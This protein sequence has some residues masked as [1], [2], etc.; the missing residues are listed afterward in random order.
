MQVSASR[1]HGKPR[2]AGAS[3]KRTVNCIRAVSDARTIRAGAC[4]ADAAGGLLAASPKR[5]CS[6][7]RSASRGRLANWPQQ[8]GGTQPSSS[9][10]PTSPSAAA[11]H[12]L[13]ASFTDSQR[14]L[15][16]SAPGGGGGGGL[17][18]VAED[19]ECLSQT[20]MEMA[21]AISG[22]HAA[23]GGDKF[24]AG[25][26]QFAAGGHSAS[27]ASIRGGMRISH[28]SSGLRGGM[29]LHG[30]SA[31]TSMPL[32]AGSPGGAGRFG[33]MSPPPMFGNGFAAAGGSM[34]SLGSTDGWPK[35]GAP[36]AGGRSSNEWSPTL[37]GPQLNNLQ[38]FGSL[39]SASDMSAATGFTTLSRRFGSLH[40][41]SSDSLCDMAYSRGPAGGSHFG[42]GSFPSENGPPSSIHHQGQYGGPSPGGADTEARVRAGQMFGGTSFAS[43]APVATV[44]EP[45]MMCMPSGNG[46][47]GAPAGGP[48]S[49][50]C[51]LLDELDLGA[52]RFAL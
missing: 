42:G 11:R 33:T 30:F 43:M 49:H 37:G 40:V 45:G 8:N 3:R 20:E 41:A 9:L 27:E 26:G 28:S 1:L 44:P 24:P 22:P 19:R 13:S 51:S 21:T 4:S 35:G 16:D 23:N 14:L 36:T 17:G 46:G 38:H 18:R 48:H 32:S 2:A 31:P 47:G 12:R 15:G 34:M 29:P 50:H 6:L 7:S 39:G 52:H 5:A 25:G 10:P